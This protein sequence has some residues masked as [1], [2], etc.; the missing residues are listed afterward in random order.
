MRKMRQTAWGQFVLHLI[1][2]PSKRRNEN[3]EA[4]AC[5]PHISILPNHPPNP[6]T[7]P[8]ARAKTHEPAGFLSHSWMLG[9]G[10]SELI[11]LPLGRLLAPGP[12]CW[13]QLPRAESRR[14]QNTY[15]LME[16]NQPATAF[17]A[18]HSSACC[19]ALITVT[20]IMIAAFNTCHASAPYFFISLD[21]FLNGPY[22]G[23]WAGSVV[24]VFWSDVPAESDYTVFLET[25]LTL[26]L[27]DTG[28]HRSWQAWQTGTVWLNSQVMQVAAAAVDP[29]LRTMAS[30]V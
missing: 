18:T 5:T 16:N 14:S 20:T 30:F 15:F 19:F 27:F 1:S 9:S 11:T 21:A 4:P 26:A 29:A 28:L 12:S 24:G 8:P 6:A 17:T 3:A 2:P 7:K 22:G 10:W 23:N 25:C 13:A